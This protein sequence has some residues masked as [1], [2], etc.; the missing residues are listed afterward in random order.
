[1]IMLSNAVYTAYD[2]ANAAGWSSA[3]GAR[4][5]RGV[6]GF[7]G[8]TITDSLDGAAHARRIADG[9]LAIRAA[10]AGTD[11]ILVTGSEATSQGVYAL[12]MR[13]DGP[14]R[15]A[16]PSSSPRIAASGRSNGRCERRDD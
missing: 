10:R 13:E 1:M 5:L 16:E 9:P 3:I 8:V 6:L 11:M 2:G 4:L 14:A 12:L 7:R 15:S